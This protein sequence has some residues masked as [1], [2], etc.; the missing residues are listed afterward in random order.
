MGIV[1]KRRDNANIVK[2]IYGGI[3]DILL[4][5]QDLQESIK[6]LN[7]ELSDFFINGITSINDLIITKSL[8]SYKDPTKIAHKVLADRIGSRDPGNKPMANDRV[9]YVYIKSG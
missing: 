5:K 4:N 8:K 7:D 1:L 3:I 2:K 6:F 9:P